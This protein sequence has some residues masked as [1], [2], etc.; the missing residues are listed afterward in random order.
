[1]QMKMGGQKKFFSES[2]EETINLQIPSA[3]MKTIFC[4]FPTSVSLQPFNN[5]Y[6]WKVLS[7]KNNFYEC[8]CDIY[9]TKTFNFYLKKFIIEIFNSF[10]YP[11]LKKSFD[12]CCCEG[13]C[14]KLLNILWEE[15][16]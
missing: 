15:K 5:F 16:S 14:H 3:D 9:G 4:S 13:R 10:E 6:I 8:N 12:N 1:M 11:T 2:K 7:A